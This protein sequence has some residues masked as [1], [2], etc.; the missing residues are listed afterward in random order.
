[1]R[2]KKDGKYRMILNLRELNDA[3]VYHR[4]K[5]STLKSAINLLSKDCYMASI[6]WKDAHFCV[7]IC[8]EHRKLLQF[9][10]DSRLYEFQVLPNGLGSGPRIFT[11]ITK[12]FFSYLRKMGYMN[13]PYIDDSILVGDSVED[14]RNNVRETVKLSMNTGFVVHPSKSIF[15]PTQ[16]IEYL[17][18]ILNSMLMTVSVNMR[19][20]DKISLAC[21]NL[22]EHKY[23]SIMQLA[24]VV[25]L[26]VASLPG[27]ELGSIFYRRLD[28]AKNEAL[29]L[30]IACCPW[31]PLL[32]G[33]LCKSTEYS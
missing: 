25:G 13:S 17:G 33:G 28:I 24:K 16:V 2:P 29:K 30:I 5:M 4:F 11:K 19:Q 3:V 1:M 21:K 9:T 15:E 22:I 6:D 12:P 20:A 31:L 10:S 7:P 23:V 32:R 27:V 14:C 8:K 26:L 18:F